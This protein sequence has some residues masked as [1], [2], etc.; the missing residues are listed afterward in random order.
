MNQDIKTLIR[1]IK[2]KRGINQSQIASELGVSATYLSDVINKRLPYSNSLRSKISE[3]Y[4]DCLFSDDD[5]MHKYTGIDYQKVTSSSTSIEK[6][7]HLQY[8]NSSL[9]KS[10]PIGRAPEAE[11][12]MSLVKEQMKITQE[13]VAQTRVLIEE[14]KE[15]KKENRKL[16]ETIVEVGKRNVEKVQGSDQAGDQICVTR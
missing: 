4:S 2:F 16:I 3:L 15:L 10:P 11:D 14:N 8:G 6:E 12:M 13:L 5:E 9:S 7:P 1:R